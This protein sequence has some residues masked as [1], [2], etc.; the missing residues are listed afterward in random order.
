M[1]VGG[2]HGGNRGVYIVDTG[3]DTLENRGRGQTGGGVTVQ[4]NGDGTG[5]LEPGDQFVDRNG[6]IVDLVEG[7]EYAPAGCK[8]AEC[9]EVFT[10][11]MPVLMDQLSVRFTLRPGLLWSDGQPL[12][13]SDS[14]Y[15]FEVASELFPAVRPDLIRYTDSYQALDERTVEWRALPGYRD[16]TYATNFFTPLTRPVGV[17][18]M[19]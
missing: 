9:V 5:G 2:G 10:G 18:G 1:A 15:S 19:L 13:A 7:I 4:L 12:Q 14:V 16:A 6:N 17:Q 3:L 8:Q 11:D